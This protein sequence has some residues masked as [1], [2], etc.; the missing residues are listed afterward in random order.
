MTFALPSPINDHEDDVTSDPLFDRT[1]N[2]PNVGRREAGNLP[3]TK[4][5]SQMT[6]STDGKLVGVQFNFLASGASYDVSTQT[7]VLLWHNQFNAPNRMQVGDLNSGGVRLRLTS[8]TTITE[9]DYREWTIGGNDSPFAECIKGQVPF[10]IDLNASNETTADGAFNN[11]EVTRY[12]LM[13]NVE[14]IVG[15]DGN[16]NFQGKAFVLGTTG[17]STDIPTFTGTS[18]FTQAVALVQGTTFADKIGNWIRQTGNVVFMDMPFRIGDEVT[19]TTF[20]DNGLTIVSPASNSSTDPRFQL[21]DQ[22]MN[23][24][25]KLR[26]NSA[27][28]VTLTGTYLWG[29]RATFSFRNSNQATTRLTG[30]TFRGMGEFKLGSSVECSSTFDNVG[31]VIAVSPAADIDGSTFLNTFSNHALHLSGGPMDISDIRFEAYDGKHAILIED[32]GSYTLTNVFFDQSDA[33]GKDIELTHAT[34]EVT[35]NLA[36]TTTTP[37]ITNS[38][39][40][41]FVINH[42]SRVLTLVGVVAGSRLLVMDTTNDVEITNAIVS[43]NPYGILIASDGTDVELSIRIRNGTLPYKTFE[44]TATLVAPSVSVSVNQVS[45]A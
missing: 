18:D 14:H 42:P 27:D 39:T 33:T 38:G 22:A 37:R 31:T 2:S 23:V 5:A 32:A 12:A 7:K 26:D 19:P 20:N 28:T 9:T 6:E 13:I 1:I 34:G 21:T 36:G 3:I 4:F 11:T 43:T 17:T 10:V 44:T 41:T 30:A 8:G 45:D 24:H 15:T 25:I 29:T 35:I 16:W 40:G